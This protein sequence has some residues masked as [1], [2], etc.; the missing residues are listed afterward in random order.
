M[1]SN[2]W[3][4]TAAI[5]AIA[6]AGGLGSEAEA[7][8]TGTSGT[9]GT[10]GSVR[11]ANTQAA[12][13]ASLSPSDQVAAAESM[14]NRGSVLSQRVNQML[15]EARRE[16]DVIRVTCLNDKLTQINANLRTAQSRLTSFQRTVDSE[17]RTHEL[18][19]LTV[20]G[21]KLQVL[22]QEANQCVGQDLYETG[23]T[24]VVTEID[25]S[26]LPFESDPTNPQLPAPTAP[27]VVGVQDASPYGIPSE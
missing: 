12:G 18:T 22:D 24:K 9:T 26:V 4:T 14:V 2:V 19:V 7:Q 20:L 13:R 17:Q 3:K 11:A 5:L 10:D 27:S 15:D 8:T 16:A 6:V 23:P 25:T 21:Q 1:S